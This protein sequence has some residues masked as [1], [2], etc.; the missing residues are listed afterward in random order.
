MSMRDPATELCQRAKDGDL[1]AGS[2]LAT[3]S[4]T[5]IYAFLRRLCGDEDEAADLTQ[6]TFFKVWTS[7]ASFQARSSFSTWIHGIAYHVYLDWR[8]KKNM[9]DFRTDEWWTDCAAEGLNPFESAEQR[10][11]ARQLYASVERLDDGIRQAVHIHYYQGLSLA[12]TADVLQVALST[13][14]YRLQSALTVLR[15]QM[16]ELKR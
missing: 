1:D 14:K 9:T 3:L 7:L 12:E 10:D 11:L 16:T 4:H 8:R 6:K 15:A 13:V 2:E 5:R